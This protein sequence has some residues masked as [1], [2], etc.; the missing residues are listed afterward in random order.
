MALFFR[1]FVVLFAFWLASIAAAAVLVLGSG[2]PTLPEPDAWP[3]V[4]IFILTTSAFVAAFSFAPA[5]VVILLA[6]TFSL[7]SLLIYALAGGAVGLFCGYTLGFVERA[8]QF[9]VNSPFGTNFELMAAAGIAAGLV[10]WLIAGRTA[11]TWRASTAVDR[12][13]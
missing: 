13:T 4:S 2:A 10:Y 8:P 5:A 9:Q 6:E 12:P 3:I 7:R 1:F 11:G